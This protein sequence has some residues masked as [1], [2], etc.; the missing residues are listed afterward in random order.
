MSILHNLDL[1]PTEPRDD[2]W[3][4]GLH[5]VSDE[6]LLE[7]LV[8]PPFLLPEPLEQLHHLTLPELV[9]THQMPEADA[10]RLLAAI[11]LARRLYER[12]IP[13]TAKLGDSRSVYEHWRARLAHLETETF[14]VMLLDAKNRRI[15]D[16]QI[17]QGS[18]TASLV[19]PRDAYTAAVREGAVSVIFVHNH[20]SGD[21]APSDEDDRL[22]RRLREAGELLGI[23]TLDHVIVAGDTYY[24]YADADRLR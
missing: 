13:R 11:E 3:E 19:H 2:I 18:R 5:H 8:P 10:V 9:F 14:H 4:S 7:L 21:P 6:L 15:R 24:S 17:S 1:H 12:P 20:P 23:R 22:T 16:V